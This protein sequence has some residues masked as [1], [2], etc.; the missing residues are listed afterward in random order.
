MALPARPRFVPHGT[1]PNPHERRHSHLDVPLLD[2]LDGAT[3]IEIS[4]RCGH[5]VIWMTRDLVARTP[6][7]V[8]C[9]EYRERLKCRCGLKGWATI[10]AI[11]RR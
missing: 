6:G 8:T 10:A 2:A 5:A 7:A 4:C 11:G 9:G 3:H 1:M